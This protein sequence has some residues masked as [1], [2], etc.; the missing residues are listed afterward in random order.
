MHIEI[1]SIPDS[2]E[3]KKMKRKGKGSI[4]EISFEEHKLRFTHIYFMGF[5]GILGYIGY[6]GVYCCIL[7]Y[8][9]LYWGILGYIKVY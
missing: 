6:I 3:L 5:W 4:K 7:G 8:I 1:R 2:M 9:G